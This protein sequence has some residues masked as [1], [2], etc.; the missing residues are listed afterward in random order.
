MLIAIV[1]GLAVYAVVLV[2]LRAL[3]GD[4]SAPIAGML[5]SLRPRRA[6]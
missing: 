2:G 4:V 5:R 3:P 6:T 1:L